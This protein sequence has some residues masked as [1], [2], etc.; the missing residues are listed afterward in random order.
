MQQRVDIRNYVLNYLITRPNLQVFVT[1]AF[2]ALLAKIT[3]YGW[4][5]TYK[6]EQIFRNI[7]QDVK[8]FFQVN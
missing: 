5:D 6:G 1:Q 7:V 3:K 2:V 8:E 4:F